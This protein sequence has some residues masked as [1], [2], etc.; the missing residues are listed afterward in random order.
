MRGPRQSRSAAPAPG[1]PSGADLFHHEVRRDGRV[2]VAFRGVASGSAAVVEAS[3]F[4][5]GDDPERE[6]LQRPFPFPSP[7]QAQRFV[8]EALVAL[9]YL[10]C[11]VTQPD[12]AAAAA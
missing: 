12:G 11:T 3:V 1:G 5:P 4:T 2:I 8:E 7:H 9:E 6:P 10:G